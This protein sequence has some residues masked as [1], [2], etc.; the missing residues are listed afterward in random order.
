MMC[1]QLYSFRQ[2]WSLESERRPPTLIPAS[3][4]YSSLT[5]IG[6]AAFQLPQHFLSPLYPTSVVPGSLNCQ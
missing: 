6:A 4:S 2:S 5:R 3:Y 1:R